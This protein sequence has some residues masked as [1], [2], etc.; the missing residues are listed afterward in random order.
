MKTIPWYKLLSARLLLA[1]II[2][3]AASPAPASAGG[4][5]P[6]LDQK[7]QKHPNSG[8]SVRVIVQ[9][10]DWGFDHGALAKRAGGRLVKDL[11]SINGSAIELPLKMVRWLSKHPKV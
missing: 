11:A 10:A 7:V 4:L 1:L 5:A 3:L 9:F 6:D 8:D 2:V